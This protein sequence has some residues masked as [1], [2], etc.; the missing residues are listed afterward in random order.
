MEW[1][2]RLAWAGAYGRRDGSWEGSDQGRVPAGGLVTRVS[3]ETF[4]A[5]GLG[6]SEADCSLLGCS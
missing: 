6:Q 3:L 4:A 5:L 1:E 2:D